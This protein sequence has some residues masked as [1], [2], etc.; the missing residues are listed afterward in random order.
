[1]NAVWAA[2]WSAYDTD[3][4][5]VDY[6]RLAFV[7]NL[8]PSGFTLYA[9]EDED[10]G[11][12]LPVGYTGWYPIT[13]ANFSF[14]VGQAPDVVHRGQVVPIQTPTTRTFQYVFNYSMVAP[15][16]RT[17]ATRTM[18]RGLADA[19]DT[20]PH[21]GRCAITVSVDGN[22]VAERLGM[23]QLAEMVVGSSREYVFGTG[24]SATGS[25]RT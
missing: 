5:R 13:A 19:L 10:D 21:A 23:H 16:R 14:L 4:D 11:K 17:E 25:A 3:D 2:D 7:I 18:L 24:M 22:R 6:V 1:V 9:V 12:L 20:S 8:F 15:L